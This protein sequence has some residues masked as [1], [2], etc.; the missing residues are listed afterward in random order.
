MNIQ[1]VLILFIGVIIF[2]GC[3]D[4]QQLLKTNKYEEQYEMAVDLYEKGEYNKA[5]T[6]LEKI[7]PIYRG[8]K[9]ASRVAYLLADCHYKL[10]DYILAGYN[11]REFAETYPNSQ[12]TK[13]AEYKSAYCYY[14][15]SPRYSLDQESTRKAIQAFQNYI[16]KYPDSDQIQA[17]N[18]YIE[19]LRT[20]L[21]K[22]AFEG[23]KLYYELRDF[24]AA[25]IALNNAL[26]EYPDSKFREDL[27]YY[28]L[29]SHYLLAKNSI[30]SKQQERYEKTIKKYYPLVD[31]YPDSEY[32]AEAK[33]IFEKSQEKL[34]EIESSSS[35]EYQASNYKD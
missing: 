21:A 10:E 15:E 14:L 22:K 33:E 29:K 25:T 3:S 18:K 8:S 27:L 30:K 35:E 19:K 12:Y 7:K 24:E 6:L 1:K 34:D 11:F 20:K 13:E 26:Q 31:E 17:C 32:T 9:H 23:A 16:R 4:Y 5:L 28:I 2:A